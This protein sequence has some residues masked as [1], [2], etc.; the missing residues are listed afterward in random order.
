M[1]PAD[2]IRH[3]LINSTTDYLVKWFTIDKY[4]KGGLLVW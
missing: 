3:Y 4:F 2:I 1:T